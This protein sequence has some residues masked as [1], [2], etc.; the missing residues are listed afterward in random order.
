[1][2]TFKQN[3]SVISALISLIFVATFVVWTEIDV[4]SLKT[5]LREDGPIEDLSAILFG[6]SS[7]CFIIFACRSHSLKGKSVS[8]YF[9][10]ACWA[11]LMFVF[12]GEEISWGQRIF[13][14]TSPEI[15][16]DINVQNEINLHNMKFMDEYFGGKYRYLS[17]MMI[18]T[19]LLLPL[20]ALSN[21]GKRIIQRFYFPVAPLYYAPFFIG[22]YLY[23]RYYQP[24]IGSEASE[25]REFLMSVGMFCFAITGA[26]LPNTLF[27]ENIAKADN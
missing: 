11:L 16:E 4:V 25:V 3:Q 19:G 27:R 12:M 24:I 22:A 23:G 5:Y 6:L 2:N 17:I 21:L 20:F 9:M 15:L 13:N 26:I 18:T 1:M 10:V 14:I 8:A 7:L